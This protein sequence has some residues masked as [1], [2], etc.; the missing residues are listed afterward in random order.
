MKNYQ[1]KDVEFM[2]ASEKQ[3]VLKNWIRFLKQLNTDT[4]EE[5]VD[6]Y[7]NHIPKL[8]QYFTKR[9]YEHLHLH[10]SFI[11]HY[12]RF[13]FFETYFN[14]PED[15]QLFLRQFLTGKSIEY[16]GSNWWLNG[17]YNDINSAMCEAAKEL[18]GTI[19]DKKAREQRKLDIERAKQLLKKHDLEL[20]LNE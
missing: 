3:L 5:I 15:T 12:N 11:A 20:K 18:C 19:V 9:L 8:F 6:N 7:G 10:C 13:G 4:G 17:E 14:E 16:G 2:S 1:F